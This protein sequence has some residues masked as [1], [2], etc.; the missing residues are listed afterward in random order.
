MY[1]EHPTDNSCLT[2]VKK[3]HTFTETNNNNNVGQNFIKFEGI[4][5]TIIQNTVKF[6]HSLILHYAF[7]SW[8]EKTMTKTVHCHWENRFVLQ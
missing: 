1:N 2:A 7:S 8:I 6:P 3:S 5:K 4:F